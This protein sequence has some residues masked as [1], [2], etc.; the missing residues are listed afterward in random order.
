MLAAGDRATG[1]S[2]LRELY[3]EM[4]DKPMPLDLERLWR[5]LGVSLAAGE[6]HYDEEAPLAEIRRAITEPPS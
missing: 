3:R 5:E 2:V 1:T 4:S 6:V